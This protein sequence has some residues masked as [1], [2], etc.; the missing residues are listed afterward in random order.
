[1][2]TRKPF[3][4]IF[5]SKQKIPPVP[6]PYFDRAKSSLCLDCVGAC[7]SACPE[8]IV[9]KPEQHMPYLDTQQR[10]CT[11]CRACQQ[12][13]QPCGG[14]LEGTK[15]DQIEAF[16]YLDRQACLSYQ[17]VVCFACKDACPI[18]AIHLRGMFEP[19]VQ[20][21]C[22]GCGMCVG[23]CPSNAILLIPFHGD[24]DEYF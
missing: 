22:V 6:L 12:A 9:I 3:R 17:R 10:G 19:H 8:K 16:A 21:S 13:C 23:V 4:E 20:E 5:N 15:G 11:F 7:V 24:S 1:M 2:E 14:V 18:D